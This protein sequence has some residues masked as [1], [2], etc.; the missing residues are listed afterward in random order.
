[1]QNRD[2]LFSL[3]ILETEKKIAP[4]WHNA[5]IIFVDWFNA[6]LARCKNIAKLMY[7]CFMSITFFWQMEK[8]DRQ[9]DSRTSGSKPG[10]VYHAIST[11]HIHQCFPV[12]CSQHSQ[13][14]V[15]YETNASPF[16]YLTAAQDY[17]YDC[18]ASVYILSQLNQL[19]ILSMDLDLSTHRETPGSM[20]CEQLV[21]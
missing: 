12:R 17:F 11:M 15:A 3:M 10:L 21:L 20:C 9:A 7:I 14:H 4:K 16:T 18:Y 1:M 5:S 2:N 8:K 19:N 6:L 13:R